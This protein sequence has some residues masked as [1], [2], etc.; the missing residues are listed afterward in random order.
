MCSDSNEV[1]MVW[2]S[3]HQYTLLVKI[4]FL[5]LSD[6]N[7]GNWK[8]YRFLALLITSHKIRPYELIYNRWNKAHVFRLRIAFLKSLRLELPYFS[9]G[10]YRKR[11]YQ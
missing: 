10:V 2:R 9:I 4:Y 1:G 3:S 6:H 11:K 7:H 8:S 5:S